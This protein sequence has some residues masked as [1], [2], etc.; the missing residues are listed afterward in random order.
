M[1]SRSEKKNS[2]NLLRLLNS[3]ASEYLP[4]VRVKFN[5]KLP[6][7]AGGLSDLQKKLIHISPKQEVEADA[8]SLGYRYAY[9]VGPKYR[10]MKLRRDEIY[11]LTLLHEIGH[12]LIRD[13][14][15]KSYLKLRDSM[16][17][18]AHHSHGTDKIYI[19]EDHIRRRKNES[20]SAWELRIADFQSWLGLGETIS[21]HMRV[22]NW[23]IDEFEKRRKD[24]RASLD[25][26]GSISG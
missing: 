7:G 10:G 9:R 26:A 23:A 4:A 19:I 5:G 11:F 3:F 13:K 25:F 6:R 22:E 17:S 15:P 8:I 14:I 16:L 18:E 12:F 1:N 2:K 24:I 20:E 21:H